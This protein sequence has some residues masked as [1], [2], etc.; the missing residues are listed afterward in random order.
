MVPKSNVPGLPVRRED[1]DARG[2]RHVMI[3][4]EAG[5]MCLKAKD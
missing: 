1:T 2:E 3:E 4:A 5:V